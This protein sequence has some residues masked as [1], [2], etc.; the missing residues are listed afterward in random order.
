MLDKLFINKT[1]K[2]LWKFQDEMHRAYP[3]DNGDIFTI[4][5]SKAIH[6]MQCSNRHHMPTHVFVPRGTAGLRRDS[7][8]IAENTQTIPKEL[9]LSPIGFVE[10]D[11]L[12]AV[13]AARS[14]QSPLPY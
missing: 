6:A 14:I 12:R 9:L 8:I 4:A 5:E 13:G 10:D 1:N 3:I 7:I 2:E 11:V